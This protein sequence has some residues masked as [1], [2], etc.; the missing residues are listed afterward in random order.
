MRVCD[1]DL[2][3]TAGATPTALHS[4]PSVDC[5]FQ[6]PFSFPSAMSS[7]SSTAAS[8]DSLPA[9]TPAA[10]AATG[11]GS[12]SREGSLLMKRGASVSALAVADVAQPSAEVQPADAN[13]E[14]DASVAAAAAAQR[15]EAEGGQLADAMA[16]FSKTFG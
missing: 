6:C 2:T 16:D 13:A 14:G 1:T 15:S 12:L 11:A 5:S 3:M 10:A 8:S 4:L 7:S 9:S